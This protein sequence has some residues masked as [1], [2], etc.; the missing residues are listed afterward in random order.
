MNAPHIGLDRTSRSIVSAA[1]GLA[2]AFTVLR[3]G[4]ARHL[5]GSAR[6]G[7]PAASGVSSAARIRVA[8]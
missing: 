4:I 8:A 2:V 6:G 1:A 7:Q 5:A 3:F